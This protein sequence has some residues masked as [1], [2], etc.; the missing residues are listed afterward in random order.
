[1]SLSKINDQKCILSCEKPV[2]IT[3][4]IETITEDKWK[5]IK[6]K[7]FDWKNLDNFGSVYDKINWSEGHIGLF[8]HSS[9][10]TSL[11]NPRKLEQSK[12]RKADLEV[13]S[14]KDD[15]SNFE[16][17][18]PKQTRATTRHLYAKNVYSAWVERIT[19]KRHTDP[20]HLLSTNEGW[21]KLKA[22]IQYINDTTMHKR[23]SVLIASTPDIE[24]AVAAK[25]RYHQ[26]CYKK[27]VLYPLSQCQTEDC[28]DHN[29]ANIKEAQVLFFQKVNQ[30]IFQEH[31]LR[32]LQSLVREYSSIL[33]TYGY[34]SIAKSSYLKEILK[35]EF[36]DN[37]DFYSTKDPNQSDMVFDSTAA[38]SYLEAASMSWCQR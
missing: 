5:N 11:S 27:Y 3:D 17:S 16:C 30:M 18:A 28:S 37:I 35:K 26:S 6:R 24:A 13:K 22:C 2:F 29:R 10:Y 32:S 19:K 36:G 34:D 25:I 31:E 38:G 1:M 21:S 14:T 8:M 33:S 9:C 20:E 15:I 12:K 7:A 23:L 4:S